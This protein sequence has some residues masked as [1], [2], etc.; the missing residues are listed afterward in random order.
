[1]KIGF[2]ISILVYQGSG[3][4]T[5]TY[6]LVKNFLEIDRKNEYR[7]FYSSFRRPSG[8]YYLSELKKLGAKVYDYHFPPRF[9]KF[10]W[11]K[12][13]VFPVEWFIGKVDIFHSSDF[14]RPPLLKTTKGIT[15]IHDLTWKIYPEFHTKDII[16]AHE[17]KVKKT[18]KFNDTIIVDSEKTKSDLLKYYPQMK[19]HMH[20]IPL[21]V[22]NRFFKK[23]KKEEI[24][25]VL[26]KYQINDP[27][28]LYVGAIEPRKNLVN[29]VK[30]YRN[31][32]NTYPELNLVLAG[33]A[34]WKNEEVFKTIKKLKIKNKVRITGFIDDKD[35]PLLYQGTRLFVYPSLYEGFGLPPLES[36]VSGAPTL[37]YNS[38]SIPKSFR[39][40]FDLT[41]DILNMLKSPLRKNIKI[42]KWSDV[43]KETLSVYESLS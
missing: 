41:K 28:I 14:L 38:P 39:T 7:L 20:T 12:H 10:C 43:A 4:A 11:N 5:Y 22:G 27:Y 26:S 15:T 42:N 9:L 33:R 34:G 19:N 29:L 8:F 24:R 3:V 6:N 30:A 16:E 2:D 37:A 1:M 32:L 21:G 18:L 23:N 25:Q 17:R 13:E 40:N 36:I 31:I 35:L